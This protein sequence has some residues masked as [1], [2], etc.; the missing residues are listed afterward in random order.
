MIRFQLAGKDKWDVTML[1]T[2]EIVYKTDDMHVEEYEVTTDDGYILTLFRTYYSADASLHDTSAK[3]A[4]F[5]QHGIQASSD[6]WVMSTPDRAP[7]LI[8]A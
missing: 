3:P 7:A 6:D 1:N 5:M 4:I 2:M 8:A